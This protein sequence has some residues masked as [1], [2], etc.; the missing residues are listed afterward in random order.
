ME[1]GATVAVGPPVLEHQILPFLEDRRRRVPIERVL[2]DHDLVIRQKSLFAR[3]V[4]VVCRIGLI[5]IVDR[6]SI[7][8]A[9]G[10]DQ[11]PV[12]P[13]FADRR[14]RKEDEHFVFSR[15]DR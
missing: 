7:D 2:K 1:C 10:I 4:D 14:V 15:H 9:N 13:R 12:D 8:T 11:H 3:D 6:D 5:E